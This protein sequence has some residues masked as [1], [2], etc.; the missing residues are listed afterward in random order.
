M[1]ENEKANPENL[2]EALINNQPV[3]RWDVFRCRKQI[4]VILEERE[5]SEDIFHE[6]HF[7]IESA[8]ESL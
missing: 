2:A 8:K 7:L 5:V 4:R 3:N 6:F 1:N